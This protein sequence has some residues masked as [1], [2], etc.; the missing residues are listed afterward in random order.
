MASEDDRDGVL[1]D[2]HWYSG[3][4]GG[5]F[6]GY[7]L[8][9]IIAGAFHA[10]ALRAEP[11]IPDEISQG[12]FGLLHGWLAQNIYRHGH[13]FTPDELI[14]RVTGG[15]LTLEPY[16]AYLRAKYSAIYGL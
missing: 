16:K 14:R 11:S 15:P 12:R 9:N 1:Q 10:A 2:V 3:P 8:G 5:V 13:K 4:I 7:T 6:Q